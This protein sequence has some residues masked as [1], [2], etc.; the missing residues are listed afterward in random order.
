MSS[1]V[2]RS[3]A[4]VDG[5]LIVVVEFSLEDSVNGAFSSFG[6]IFEVVVDDRDSVKLDKSGFVVVE[7]ADCCVVKTSSEESFLLE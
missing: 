5:D 7:T 4:A 1:I 2:C 6:I 3:G